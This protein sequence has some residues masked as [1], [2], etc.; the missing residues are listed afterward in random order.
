MAPV[1]APLVEMEE[2][3]SGSLVETVDVEEGARC[4]KK[5][6]KWVPEMW[7]RG[8]LLFLPPPLLKATLLAPG[9]TE[10]L[11]RRP[12]PHGG[13]VPESRGTPF[14]GALCCARLSKSLDVGLLQQECVS[15]GLQKCVCAR[16]QLDISQ[17]LRAFTRKR[18]GAFGN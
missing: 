13:R 7:G 14:G 18:A 10:R 17:L 11:T 5:A 3:P 15:R 2:P 12:T 6:P 9:R 1:A 8:G 16:L 4:A